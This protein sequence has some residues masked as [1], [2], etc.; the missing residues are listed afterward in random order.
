MWQARAGSEMV[1]A[2]RQALNEMLSD[3]EMI[4]L[5]LQRQIHIEEKTVQDTAAI[6]CTV[7]DIAEM[8]DRGIAGFSARMSKAFFEVSAE[9]AARCQSEQ[10]HWT[11]RLCVRGLGL[12][13][14]ESNQTARE[15]VVECGELAAQL[16]KLFDEKSAVERQVT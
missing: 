9:K 13:L 11:E 2:S 16:E 12:S 5:D 7:G 15:A 8:L 10:L 4:K 1:E 3:V 14:V 6:M